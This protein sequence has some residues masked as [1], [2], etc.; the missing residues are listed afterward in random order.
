M[1]ESSW[2]SELTEDRHAIRSP[3][4]K[5]GGEGVN[6]AG[7]FSGR[8]ICETGKERRRGGA[9]IERDGSGAFKPRRENGRNVPRSGFSID[10]VEEN[11]YTV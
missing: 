3:E 9:L 7:V 1:P 2:E 10:M 8:R 11:R 5:G 6:T 4:A